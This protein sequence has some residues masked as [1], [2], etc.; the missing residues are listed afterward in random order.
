MATINLFGFTIGREDKQSQLKKQS[1]ITPLADDGAS[2]VSAGGYYGTFVDIDASARSE[3]EMIS[4]YREIS[5]YPDCDTAIEEIVVEAIAAVDSEA[6]VTINLEM[7]DV[8]ANIKK[9]ITQEFEEVLSLL[10]FKDKAHDIFRR[11]Y[12][13][14]RLY[15]QKLVNPSQTK[16]GIQELRFIDPRKIRKVREIKK[17][18][19]SSGVE[20]VETITEFFIY[21]EKG[22]NY[23][24]GTSPQQANAGIRISTDAIAFC[25]SGLLDLDRN[26]VIG[27]LHKAIKPVNQLKMMADSLVIYRLSRAPERRIFYIDVGNLPKIK[28]EQYMKD[29]M[30]RYRNKIVYDSSTG[31][32]K[33]DR[34]FMTMLEDFWLPRREGGRGTEITTLP[35]GCFSMDTKVSLLD[36]RELSISDI[37]QEMSQGK[38]L[39][40]YSCDEFTGEVKPG[41]ISWA[42]VTQESAQVMKLT[43][44]NGE[45]IICTPDHKFPIYGKGFVE[46]KD[47]VVGESLIPLYREKRKIAKNSKLEYEAVFDNKSKKWVFTHR[48]VRSHIKLDVA[49]YQEIFNDGFVVHHKDCNRFNN[50]PQNLRMMSRK[51]HILYHKSI[52]FEPGVGTAASIAK[53]KAEKELNS[54]WYQEK[55]EKSSKN[56]ILYWS[57]LTD[58]QRAAV[59][60]KIRSGIHS[61]ISSL[62]REQREARAKDSRKNALKGSA[63][64]QQKLRDDPEFKVKYSEAHK[65]WWTEERRRERSVSMQEIN[66]ENWKNEKWAA[67]QRINHKQ[68][69]ELQFDNF[70]FCS[71]VDA[72]KGK[73]THQAT[74]EDVVSILNNNDSSVK[75]LASLNEAKSVPNWSPKIGFTSNIVKKCVTRFGGFETWS[76]FRKN[77]DLHNHRVVSIEY[78]DE[79]IQVGTLRI[80]DLEQ[81]H[82]HHTFAL[83]A[84][85]FTKNSNLGEIDDIKFFQDKVYQALNV[86]NS[87]FQQS[88]GFNFG[89]AAEISRDEIKFA[90]FISRLRRKFNVLFDSLL[91][92]Q[93]VLKGII[94]A[95]DWPAIKEKLDY[96]YAQ[97]QYFQEIKDAENLRNRLDVVNQMNPY[98]GTY[99]SKDYIRRHILK[100]STDE[101]EQISKE[102][103]Q[104]AELQAQIQGQQDSEQQTAPGSLQTAALSREV[105]N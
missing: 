46:A 52:P 65:V 10:D 39:W 56:S 23:T 50:E 1:F 48:M 60:S 25:P 36:G 90:K 47:F 35:G 92:T 71:I 88:S 12:V 31:E 49:V 87:R 44:D 81:I 28:A 89:R 16:K 5:N 70:I 45:H 80:D 102:N 93:L 83:S 19:L 38:I 101:V 79:K 85:V 15:Y 33:D 74:V 3:S 6:P 21:N 18:R 99:F 34:K 100:L 78:L 96:D 40:T 29:I 55:I 17:D 9:A 53:F 73:T 61:Y 68:N 13:D 32:I 86:P 63:A 104:D 97:D 58:E 30:N 64:L 14:G 82:G 41:L 2:T 42:G 20:V 37:E 11:W 62:S 76:E 72:I 98:V 57:N 24:P 7:V 22:L 4:R 91:E 77:K 51:D 75:R 59:S 67:Q 95:D 105:N 54:E 8:S 84:G 94:T 43:L 27:Y 26:V 103:E 66:T 69:Q